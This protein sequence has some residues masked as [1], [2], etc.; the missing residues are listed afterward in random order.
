MLMFDD[1]F[2]V[3]READGTQAG[4]GAGEAGQAGDPPPADTKLS[5]A[6]KD[7]EGGQG[8]GEAGQNGTGKNGEAGKNGADGQ[9]GADGGEGEVYWPEGL[10]EHLAELKGKTD[11]ETIDKLAGKLSEQAQPPEKPDGYELSLSDAFKEKFGDLSDDEVLPIWRDIAH[12]NG[13]SNEQFNG[14]ISELYS[15]L[16][17]KGILDE[18]INVQEE[19]KKLAPG[20]ADPVQ[21]WGQAAKRINGVTDQVE[22]LVKRGVLNRTEGNVVTAM[23]ASAEGVM[24]LEKVLKLGSEQGLQGGG[25]GGGANAGKSDY[26]QRLESMYPS[27]VNRKS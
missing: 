25:Q 16:S 5:K 21:A 13:L 4:T 2:N 6:A 23:A 9:N 24:A 1:L 20:V 26:Q 17:E 7:A 12:K 15:Q 14:A 27:M 18:G 11:Q 10:P 22:G 8:E 3:L 19:M